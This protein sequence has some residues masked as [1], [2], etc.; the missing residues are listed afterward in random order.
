[1]GEYDYMDPKEYPM[2]KKLLSFAETHG[3]DKSKALKFIHL[4]IGPASSSC[5]IPLLKIKRSFNSIHRFKLE[6]NEIK[7]SVNREAFNDAQMVVEY[8]D[9]LDLINFFFNVFLKKLILFNV[10]V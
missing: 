8:S 2:H 10:N 5:Q 3:L 1:M 4:K 6:L 9:F 7:K